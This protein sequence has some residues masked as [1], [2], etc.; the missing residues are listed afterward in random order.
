MNAEYIKSKP[1]R[2]REAG[3]DEKWLQDL[4]CQDPSILGLGEVSVLHREKAQP[5]GGRIDLI[6]ADPD[7]TTWY[8]T[9]I[10]LG[11]VNESHIIR[12]IE[13][14]DVERRRYPKLKHH[15]VIIAEEITNRFFNVIS[16]LNKAVPIIAIQLNGLMVNKKLAVS[17][18]KV[19]DL[20]KEEDEPGE[21]VNRQ[22]WD[23]KASAKSLA[24]MDQII[25]LVPKQAGEVRVKYNRGHVAMGTS[26]SNFC[27][28]H[29][30]KGPY[31]HLNAWVGP[32][33]RKAFAKKLESEGI[34]CA[35]N[36]SIRI[37]LT[38]QKLT[39]NKRLIQEIISAAEQESHE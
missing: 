20:T 30:R 12:T 5:S 11:T 8:E 28:F 31:V 9:E 14:W 38:E 4:I 21:E 35:G 26:G 32:D 27:W 34:E 3:K 17:F 19:L 29:P 16:L 2:L 23:A 22:Y 10:M 37:S 25:G 33:K 24:I 15:A 13:Y 1:I 39:A 6:L 36:S 7:E 18:V